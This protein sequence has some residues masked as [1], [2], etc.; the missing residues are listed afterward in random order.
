[1]GAL[2]FDLEDAPDFFGK[3]IQTAI[4]K[5]ALNGLYSA[6]LLGVVEIQTRIIPQLVP[7]PVDRGTYKAGWGA[8]RDDEGADIENTAPH[9]VFIEEGVRAAAVR[10]GEAMISALAEWVIRKGIAEKSKARSVAFGIARGMQRRGIF[11]QGLQVLPKL[12][13]LMPNII[14]KEVAREVERAITRA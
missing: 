11:G 12:E 6:A 13:V 14:E 3:R 10:V 5:G 4:R 2:R 8:V 9:A 1:M 7:Q